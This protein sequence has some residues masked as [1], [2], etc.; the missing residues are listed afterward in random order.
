MSLREIVQQVDAQQDLGAFLRANHNKVPPR[1]GE[2][3]YE[4][5]PVSVSYARQNRQMLTMF[6][7][8]EALQEAQ[9]LPALCSHSRANRQESNLLPL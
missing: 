4:R 9:L 8:W 7:S 6:R 3:K 1:T 2:P 5:H